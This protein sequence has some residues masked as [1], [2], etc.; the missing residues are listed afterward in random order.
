MNRHLNNKG[1]EWKLGHAKGRALMGG[2]KQKKEVKKVNM[3]D[4]LFIQEWI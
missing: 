3:F 2:G 1:Q 4:V